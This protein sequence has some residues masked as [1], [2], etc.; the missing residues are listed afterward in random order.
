MGN[1]LVRDE[2]G[3]DFC[4]AQFTRATIER[5]YNMSRAIE[6]YLDRVMIYANLGE[7]AVQVRAELKDHLLEKIDELKTGGLS[8][9]D[10]AFQAI[11]DHGHPRTVGYGLRKHFR[12]I[13]VRTYGT[14]RGF[15]AVGPKAV[16]VIAMGGVAFGLFAFGGLAVGAIAFGGLALA[17][18]LSFGGLSAAVIGFAYGGVALGLIA[19]GGFACGIIATGGM[20]IGLIV[21]DAGASI[22]LLRYYPW[23]Y[24]YL[25]VVDSILISKRLTIFATLAFWIVFVIMI[26]AYSILTG[27]EYRRIKNADPKLAE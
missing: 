2:E 24:D 4:L 19:V 13:D 27:R 11:E 12:W 8:Q 18:L 9:E 7:E 1:A 22:S 25:L 3:F 26:P 21:P 17:A 10:A 5:S 14:A 6:K 16:G 15:I 20:A 23:L